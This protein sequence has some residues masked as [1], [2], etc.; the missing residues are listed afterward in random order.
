MF[1][2][3]MSGRH[4]WRAAVVASV[5]SCSFQDFDYLQNKATSSSTSSGGGGGNGGSGGG[6][7]SLGSSNGGAGGST[8]SNSGAS[9]TGGGGTGGSSSST[10]SNTS[11][12]G[13]GGDDGSSTTLGFAGAA[14][15]FGGDNILTNSS[16]E[17][18]WTGWSVEPEA[19]RNTHARVKWPQPGSV[20]PNGESEEF[21]L[22]TWHDADAYVLSVVQP[23]DA[24]EDGSYGLIGFFNW[25]GA[26]NAVRMFARNCGGDDIYQDVQPTADTQWREVII[27][28]IEVVGG[29][30]E[31]GLE[32]DSN[33]GG[34]L[35]ADMFSFF[36]M[37]PN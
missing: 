12:G 20:T 22:G 27:T 16:F 18:G 32:I 10:T 30:C 19:S 23:V 36:E 6:G 11:T 17:E 24:L 26:V 15:A 5:V 37:D 21:L 14:G 1:V 13:M 9:N 35:N 7:G 29:H 8:A 3:P 33:P 34:W 4:V 31:V 28:D 25:G 2:T